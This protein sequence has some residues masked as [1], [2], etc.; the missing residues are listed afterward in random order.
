ME[1]IEDG[2]TLWKLLSVADG[3]FLDSENKA[4][5]ESLVDR[6]TDRLI[7]GMDVEDS[8]QYQ[9]FDPVSAERWKAILKAFDGTRVR[10][11]SASSDFSKVVV[12]LEGAQIGISLRANRPG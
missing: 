1:S 5:D 8:P 4:F 11:I 12:L 10:Y 2:K 6:F 3:K 7:G 9:F